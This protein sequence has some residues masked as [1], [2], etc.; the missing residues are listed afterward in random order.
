M[1]LVDVRLGTHEAFDRIVFELAGGG[2][3]GWEVGYTDS[4]LSQG[5]GQPVEVPGEATLGITLTTIAL[6]GD[7]P[8][9]VQPWN[10]PAR[11]RVPGTGVLDALV[12]DTVLDGW[13]TFFAGLDERRPFAVG[14][15][16]DPQ[17]IVVDLV[18]EQRSGVVP[19]GQRCESPAGFAVSYPEGWAV[20]DGD[21]A[22]P[23]TRFAPDPFT[24]PAG[25]DARVGAVTA[26]VEP[27]AVDQVAA[28]DPQRDLQRSETTVDGRPAVRVERES[29]GRGLWPAGT[30]WTG[31]V[32]GLPDGEDGPRTLV[33][34]TV[35]LPQ[36]DYARN[37]EVLDRM[38]ETLEV[39]AGD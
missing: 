6:P 1:T 19:L 31:Y 39:T 5:S 38:V 20:N 26:S 25:T 21:I 2:L 16:S 15:L 24:V 4:P 32:V 9:G 22:P 37:V 7:A 35:E 13:A 28:P 8:A 3:A 30:R 36:F 14:L 10:G 27:A 18:A 17:R 34:D 23:C 33:V 11:L 12:R 29:R